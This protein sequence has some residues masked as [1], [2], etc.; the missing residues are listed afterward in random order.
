MGKLNDNR[1]NSINPNNLEYQ[2]PVANRSNQSYPDN[3]DHGFKQVVFEK[4]II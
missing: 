1:S 3:S 2:M 4:V